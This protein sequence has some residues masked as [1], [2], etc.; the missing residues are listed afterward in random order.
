MSSQE[1]LSLK[2]NV[3]DVCSQRGKIYIQEKTKMKYYLGYRFIYSASRK[4]KMT[5]LLRE[6]I[7]RCWYGQVIWEIKIQL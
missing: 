3:F 1:R 4:F 2:K 7:G 6:G 5:I